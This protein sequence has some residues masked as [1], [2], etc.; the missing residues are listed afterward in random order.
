M[1]I[2]QRRQVNTPF[3]T[4]RLSIDRF[5]TEEF[6]QEYSV[7][8]FSSSSLPYSEEEKISYELLSKHPEILSCCYITNFKP[9]YSRVGL[10]LVKKNERDS[11]RKLISSEYPEFNVKIETFLEE[12]KLQLVKLLILSYKGENTPIFRHTSRY[13]IVS[14]TNFGLGD[15][16]RR[17]QV[18][19]TEIEIKQ[20]GIIIPKTK[21]FT[22]YSKVQ[23]LITPTT[24]LYVINYAK[25]I[26]SKLS[27]TL[28]E[29]LLKEQPSIIYAEKNPSKKK[30][31]IPWI[32]HEPEEAIHG[33][34]YTLWRFIESA[35]N[36]FSRYFKLSLT[37]IPSSEEI[38]VNTAASAKEFVC[39]ILNGVQ[40]SIHDTVS[41][42]ESQSVAHHIETIIGSKYGELINLTSTAE[43]GGVIRIVNPKPKKRESVKQEDLYSHKDPNNNVVQNIMLDKTTSE[44]KTIVDRIMLELAVKHSLKHQ[45]IPNLPQSLCSWTF[46]LFLLCK[47]GEG[48]ESYKFY[49]CSGINF[50]KN[51]SIQ[52]KYSELSLDNAFINQVTKEANRY[53]NS[54]RILLMTRKV[55]SLNQQFMII[56][57][58]IVPII[59]QQILNKDNECVLRD[60]NPDNLEKYLLHRGILKKDVESAFGILRNL[61]DRKQEPLFHGRISPKIILAWSKALIDYPIISSTILT[62]K[63]EMTYLSRRK[64]KDQR[65][66][67]FAAFHNIHY[68]RNNDGTYSYVSARNDSSEQVVWGSRTEKAPHVRIV[69]PLQIGHTLTQ[70]IFEEIIGMLDFGFGRSLGEKGDAMAYPFPN[71]YLEEI[72]KAN[73]DTR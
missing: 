27:S 35:N 33:K 14:P 68:W 17:K 65:D 1:S 20:N 26:F 53:G 38:T 16:I 13:I 7:V 34:G 59:E 42:L 62:Y 31:T 12:I 49:A 45:Y 47:R 40:I 46:I 8:S 70:E 64:N 69:A 37:V 29:Q 48:K 51:G 61:K 28:K 63:N 66:I 3:K 43:N 5:C 23:K 2:L 9:L 30:N 11:V 58:D 44:L 72:I 73:M 41:S 55:N 67:F 39:N 24:P 25:G 36:H 4:N 57:T 60:S 22:S 32:V 6:E 52:Q 10:L 21:T 19:C 54:T 18:V 50:S 71:K 15:S 56:D